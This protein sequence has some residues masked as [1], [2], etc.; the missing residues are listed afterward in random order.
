MFFKR[1]LFWLPRILGILFAIFISLFALDVFSENSSPSQ[2]ILALLIHLI[3]TYIIVLALI[4]SWKWE[5]IGAIVF[6]SLAFAYLGMAHGR[7]HLAAYLAISGP[8]FLIGILFFIS[9]FTRE[10]SKRSKNSL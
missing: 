3:P 10:V 6:I 9:W 7:F 8:L 5:W 2:T 1:L 4:L